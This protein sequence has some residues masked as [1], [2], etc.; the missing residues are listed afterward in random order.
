MINLMVNKEDNDTDIEEENQ[1]LVTQ[2]I[3]SEESSMEDSKK[4]NSGIST[5]SYK[6]VNLISEKSNSHD[7]TQKNIPT[8]FIHK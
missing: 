5:C 6:T 8:S 4:E 3:S 2:E 1:V 7:F